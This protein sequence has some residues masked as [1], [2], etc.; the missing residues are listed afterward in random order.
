MENIRKSQKKLKDYYLPNMLSV[1]VS[2]KNNIQIKEKLNESIM[3]FENEKEIIY[4]IKLLSNSNSLLINNSSIL[5]S[6]FLKIINTYETS[7]QNIK[8]ELLYIQKELLANK[9]IEIKNIFIINESKENKDI[10]IDKNYLN[11][12]ELDK[13]Y[14]KLLKINWNLIDFKDYFRNPEQLKKN[15]I[16]IY[17]ELKEI[18]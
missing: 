11:L 5:L 14:N 15:I 16:K 17:S 8:N 7:L 6:N 2:L 1:L 12:I 4:Y 3:N 18:F 10:K 13:T 9:E